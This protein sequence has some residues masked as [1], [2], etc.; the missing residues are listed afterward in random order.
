MNLQLTYCYFWFLKTHKRHLGF[1]LPVLL[2]VLQ[3]A[4][5]AVCIHS[6]RILTA[7]VIKI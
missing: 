6:V 2:A 5:A 4:A 3:F 1:L 7:E